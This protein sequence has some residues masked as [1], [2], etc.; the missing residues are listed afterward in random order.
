MKK[1]RDCKWLGL[2]LRVLFSALTLM[3]EWQEGQPA[4]KMNSTNPQ[5]FTG[6]G[7]GPKKEMADSD[8]FGK[9]GH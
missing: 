5:R 2:V 4:R 3:A 8:S 1:G 9:N 7:G 6:G